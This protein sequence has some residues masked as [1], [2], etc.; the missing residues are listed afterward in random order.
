MTR[1]RERETRANLANYKIGDSR[2]IMSEADTQTW[3]NSSLPDTGNY[4][5]YL[6]VKNVCLFYI[7]A[8]SVS[9]NIDKNITLEYLMFVQ[10][11]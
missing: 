10:K 11:I 2:L 8:D 6:E 7:S 3:Q 9:V 5:E 1:E 4:S